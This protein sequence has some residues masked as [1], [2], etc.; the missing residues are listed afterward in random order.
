M[1]NVPRGTFPAEAPLSELLEPFLSGCRRLGLSIA[2]D[3][4]TQFGRYHAEI[5]RWTARVRLVSPHDLG[6]IPARH[7]LDSILP[8]LAMDIP[9]GAALV[10]VG[11][12][13]GFPGIPIK[14]CRPNIS[15]TLIESNRKKYLFLTHLIQCLAL[16]STRALLERVERLVDDSTQAQLYD[17]ALVRAVGPLAELLPSI[18]P[19]LKPSGRLIAYKGPEPSQEIAEAE[20]ALNQWSGIVEKVVSF[21][22]PELP[23]TT[24]IVIVRKVSPD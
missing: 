24:T 4:Q 6:R 16:S 1:R 2:P 5:L 15:M 20:D 13:S 18:F 7:F 14:I 23:I 11:S 19:L 8:L 12:G 10:D 3:Q 17:L 22:L 21:S 9:H